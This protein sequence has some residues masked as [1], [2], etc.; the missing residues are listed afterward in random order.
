MEQDDLQGFERF[1]REERQLGKRTVA[2]YLFYYKHFNPLKLSEEYVHDFILKHKNS[3][4]VRAFVSNYLS[5]HDIKGIA[6]PK[7]SKGGNKVKRLIRPVSNEE[8]DAMRKHLYSKSFKEGL[9]FDLLYQ[10]ALR[11]VEV[12]TITVGS[13]KWKS[14]LDD[15]T[16]FCQMIILG[17]GNRERIVLINPETV[18]AIMNHYMKAYNLE[19][20]QEIEAF[21]TEHKDDLLFSREDKQPLTEKNI[22]D[23]I[24]RGSMKILNRDVRP[25]ELR[26]QRSSELERRGVPIHDIKNYLGHSKIATTEIYLHRTGTESLEK[27]EEKLSQ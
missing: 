19:S 26:H 11:R 6:M 23:I 9:I 10:G 8:I 16:K 1:L 14:W 25:H 24:K 22:Y 17:K 4:P 7:K 27:I 15:I 2:T 21:V 5:Y 18:E 20:V 13:F 12:I 3:N